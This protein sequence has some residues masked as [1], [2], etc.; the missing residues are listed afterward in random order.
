VFVLVRLHHALE[1][2]VPPPNIVEA[3]RLVVAAEHL[4]VLPQLRVDVPV[5]DSRLGRVTEGI[6]D[7][8][9][10]DQRALLGGDLAL[11]KCHL[12]VL[13]H[14]L[15]ELALQ[16]R[17]L[18]AQRRNLLYAP[19]A[20]EVLHELYDGLQEAGALAVLPR[21]GQPP[22]LLV[23]SREHL[24]PLERR[25]AERQVALGAV[26]SLDVGR[27]RGDVL[28]RLDG[29]RPHRLDLA[30]ELR[31]LRLGRLHALEA[32]VGLVGLL[33]LEGVDVAR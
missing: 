26:E 32:R 33:G 30:E 10:L 23:G 15:Q 22:E 3:P 24:Q 18:A 20:V 19:V 8:A 1:P 5:D 25:H 21:L 4:A 9:G 27:H 31:E 14:L 28:L 16:L 2:R 7:E 29:A 11:G 17:D 6:H 12:K 13:A